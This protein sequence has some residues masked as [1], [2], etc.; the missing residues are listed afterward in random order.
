[1]RMNTPLL[2]LLSLGLAIALHELGVY[3]SQRVCSRAQF[4]KV[5]EPVCSADLAELD[6]NMRT[7]ASSLVIAATTA[8]RCAN[9]LW[10]AAVH[11]MRG[12]IIMAVI[13]PTL[14][15]GGITV[16]GGADLM[17]MFASKCNSRFSHPLACMRLKAKLF[18]TTSSSHA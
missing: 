18:K 8:S 11:V 2:C 15:C 7:I 4:E 5:S 6:S 1:M 16:L 12:G 17:H 10:L 13:T 3:R 9:L 14:C